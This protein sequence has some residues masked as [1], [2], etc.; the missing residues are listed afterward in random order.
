MKF[1]LAL[2]RE[3]LSIPVVRRV[4]GDALRGLGVAE[5]CVGD[6][7]VAVS[8]GS[9]SFVQHAPSSADFEVVALIDRDLCVLKVVDKGQGFAGGPGHSVEWDSESGRGI[10]IMRALVDHVSFD[11]LPGAPGDT[12]TAVY[13][14]KRLTW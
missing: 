14:Q 11:T 10:S 1:S 4:L 8:E 3:A 2:P 6:I 9:T 12:G 13:L 7:L 5:D